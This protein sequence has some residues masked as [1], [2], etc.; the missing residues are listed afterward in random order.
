LPSRPSTTPATE[1]KY[2]AAPEVPTYQPP[3]PTPTDPY[4]GYYQLPSGSWATYDPAYYA[5]FSKTWQDEYDAHVRALE[6]GTAKGFEG[7]DSSSVQDVDTQKEM[8]RARVEYKER[9]D[10]KAL[11]KGAGAGPEAPNMKL[12][13]SQYILPV[14]TPVER[15]F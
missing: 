10:R 13:V 14:I 8:E 6:K 15:G 4:P 7:Y 11:T 1:N 3:E 2:S 9:E 12:T 5:T